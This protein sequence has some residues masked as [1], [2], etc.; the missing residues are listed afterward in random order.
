MYTDNIGVC[1]GLGIDGLSMKVAYVP[2]KTRY[3]VI[4]RPFTFDKAVN[5]VC[6]RGV[7]S[8]L[9]LQTG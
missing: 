1:K 6:H 3:G 5:I 8:H 7:M 9:D 4:C 2:K